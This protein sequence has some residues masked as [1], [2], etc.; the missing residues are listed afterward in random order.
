MNDKSLP[1]GTAESRPFWEAAAEGRLVYQHCGACHR[2]QFYPRVRCSHCGASELEWRTSSARAAVH[3]VTRVH[4]GNA[5]RG[6]QTP[7]TV[8]LVDVEEGFRMLVN[9]V[10]NRENVAIGARGQIV[11]ERHDG[12][13]SPLLDLD[14]AT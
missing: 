11:F 5:P 2:A 3:A 4:I 10:G 9:V 14:G 12:V 8:A 6:A 13:A 1:V 7:Y